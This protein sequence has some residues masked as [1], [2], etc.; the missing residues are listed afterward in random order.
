M[1][2]SDAT[3]LSQQRHLIFFLSAASQEFP[4]DF[5][6]SSYSSFFLSPELKINLCHL[7]PNYRVNCV[8]ELKYANVYPLKNT[9]LLAIS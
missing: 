2:E 7:G 5:L 3:G 9:V 4:V 8:L 6:S 1:L